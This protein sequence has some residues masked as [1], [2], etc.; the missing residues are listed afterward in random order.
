MARRPLKILIMG[1]PGSGKTTLAEK[2]AAKIDAFHLN[3]DK[4]RREADD[5]DFSV[6]G[7]RR[8]AERMSRLAEEAL[9]GNRHVVADFICPTEK[10]RR[11]F[12]GDLLVWMDT[13]EESRFEDTNRIFEPPK[14]WD[15]RITTFDSDRHAAVIAGHVMGRGDED[16]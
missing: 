11:E 15:F 14:E 10:T 13:I 4:V 5:W 3:A 7:R 6:E 8:Q 9:N 12:N 1:L 16:V 2:L